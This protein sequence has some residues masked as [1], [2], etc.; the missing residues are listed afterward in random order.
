MV[1]ESQDR[2]QQRLLSARTLIIR[3]SCALITK[4]RHLKCFWCCLCMFFRCID[5]IPEFRHGDIS[6]C[7]TRWEQHLPK[8]MFCCQ[9]HR[10]VL[11]LQ[12]VP[13]DCKLHI[14]FHIAKKKLQQPETGA[15]NKGGTCVLGPLF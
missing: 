1:S 5:T 10:P 11:Q 14:K 4:A 8:L 13:V 2:T 15:E 12:G 6:H 7:C 3:S 9:V